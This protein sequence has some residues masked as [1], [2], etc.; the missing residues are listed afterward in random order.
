M[1]VSDVIIKYAVI[2]FFSFQTKDEQ[3]MH[4][5]KGVEGHEDDDNGDSDKGVE[6]REDDDNGDSDN[7][8]KEEAIAENQKKGREKIRE[9]QK[10]A[11]KNKKTLKNQI[12]QYV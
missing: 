8:E 2:F 5:D 11:E 1:R 9:L 7:D 6:V 3:K 12:S 4:D 10:I